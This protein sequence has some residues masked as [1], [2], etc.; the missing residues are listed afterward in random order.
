MVTNLNLLPN[1]PIYKI[2]AFVTLCMILITTVPA[3]VKYALWEFAI[4]NKRVILKRGLIQ[5][6]IIEIMLPRIES[7]GVNQSFGG[8][9]FDYGTL[10]I[11]GIGGS[12][13]VFLDYPQPM[14]LRNLISTQI[15]K[16][17]FD[18]SAPRPPLSS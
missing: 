6:Q 13:D 15:E 2:I 4:T 1:I 18:V 3:Y 8:R 5:R 16:A 7:I 11:S 10:E 14:Q 17:N 9:I 12:K